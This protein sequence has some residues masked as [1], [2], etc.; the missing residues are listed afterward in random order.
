[1]ALLAG[2][3]TQKWLPRQVSE[4]REGGLRVLKKKAL[5][6]YT[7]LH[8]WELANGIWAVPFVLL[9]RALR[10]IVLIRLGTLFSWRIGHFVAD[11]AEQVVRILHQPTKTVDWFWLGKT[12]NSQWERMIRRSFRVRHWA[13]YMDWWNRVLPGGGAHE[14]PSSLTRSIDVE[15]LFWRY[16]AKIPFLPTETDQARAWL[17]SQ[18]WCDGEPFVCLLVRDE[19][20]L[21][22]HNGDGSLGAY[23][24]WAY[25]DYRDSDID[26]YLPAI[27][28]LADQGVWVIR[29][30]KLMAKPLPKGMDHVID[31]AFDPNRSDL[32]DM[33]LFANCTGCV[34]TSSGPD[35]VSVVYGRPL[36]FVN[37]LPMSSALFWGQSIWV[38]KTLRWASTGRV[39]S[40]QEYLVN[41][42]MKSSE[43]DAAGIAITNLSSEEVTTAVQ[44]FWQCSFGSWKEAEE[45]QQRQIDYRNTFL[46]WYSDGNTNIWLHPDAR[47][48]T[49][50]LRSVPLR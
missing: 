13:R 27:Q 22:N 20:Y 15:G 34:S 19:V 49:A 29:M 21:A 48:G 5:R 17:R 23:E 26:T 16:N 50:W 2:E 30:G 35:V 44:E 1:M 37:A 4:L 18:G 39:L 14:R 7:R 6:T 38:P 47:V 41:S 25:H 12:S 32:L 10:P 33:W 3:S 9:I 46:D 28:W 42:C 31:Y 11:G 8:L 24:G 43:Y 40:A 36:L 45:D